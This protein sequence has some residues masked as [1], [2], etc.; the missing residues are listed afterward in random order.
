MAKGGFILKWLVV[1]IFGRTL[2]T[3]FVSPRP[4]VSTPREVGRAAENEGRNTFKTPLSTDDRQLLQ[5][6]MAPPDQLMELSED[7]MIL[8]EKYPGGRSATSVFWAIVQPAVSLGFLVVGVSAYFGEPIVDWTPI[9]SEY[10]GFLR[11]SEGINFLPQGAFMSFYGFFGFFI[12]GPI[13]WYIN[14]F[15]VGQGVCEFNKNDGMMYMVRNG[16][17]IRE[18]PLTDF[19]A[20]KFEWTNLAITGSRDLYLVT[21]E[22]QEIHFMD[23]PEVY[24]KYVLEKR[25]SKLSEFLGVELLVDD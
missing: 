20:V 13:Q 14:I 4:Q 8:R 12:F 1:A 25:A 24:S 19:Q 18:I 23:D 11:P 10:L 9:T 5:D 3:A 16:D 15:N 2:Y 17:M 6:W 7:G 22:G 21:Q